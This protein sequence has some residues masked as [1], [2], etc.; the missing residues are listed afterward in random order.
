MANII[1]LTC[2]KCGGKLQITNDID[3]FSCGYCGNELIIQRSGGAITVAPI[4]EG[5]KEVKVGVDKTASE[6]AIKRLEG[7]IAYLFAQRA[8]VATHSSC[9]ILIGVIGFFFLFSSILA[10]L[11]GLS[12]GGVASLLVALLVLAP[13][14]YLYNNENQKFTKNVVPID[15]AIAEKVKELEK[16]RANVRVK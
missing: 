16:H 7:E 9:V 4:V 3:H 14:V 10:F 8:N 1:N 11:F 5:L 6:L 12:D 15:R 2:P 13:T